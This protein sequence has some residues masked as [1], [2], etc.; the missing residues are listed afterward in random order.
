[1]KNIISFILLF[2]VFSHVNAQN[3]IQN[4][5][6]RAPQKTEQQTQQARSELMEKLWFGGSLNLWFGGG[7]NQSTF[8]AGISPMVGYKITPIFSVGPRIDFSYTYFGYSFG[9]NNQGRLNL[10]SYG[11]GP[12]S[13]VRVWESIFVHGEYQIESRALP[14]NTGSGF[15]KI[16][17]I[18]S[19]LFLGIGY[20]A[21][22]GEILLLYNFFAGSR[23]FIQ[24]P[25][26]FRI[27][28]TYNF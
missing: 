18:Q 6:S 21:G 10:T 15:E 2:T 17:D 8:I 19:N 27:G 12:F 11:I 3:R 13:R 26:D 4:R 14:L 16:R 9:P 1:M 28:F 23:N 7:N 24:P 20:N 5:T 22:G 25:F